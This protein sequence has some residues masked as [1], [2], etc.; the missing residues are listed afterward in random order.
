MTPD[1]KGMRQ[2]M[3]SPHRP[4][5]WPDGV[6]GISMEGTAFVGVHT[7]TG[8]LYW[9]GKKVVI[10]KPVT[11]GTLERCLVAA[12]AVGT[13]GVFVLEHGRSIG[14]WLSPQRN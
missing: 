14:W 10:Q 1:W 5:E 8:E 7:A 12:A 6:R 11:L 2:N 4:P 13:F 3:Y 9:D